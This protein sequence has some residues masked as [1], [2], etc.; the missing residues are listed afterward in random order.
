[1]PPSAASKRPV[2]ALAPVKAPAS[3]P[4]SSDSISVSGSAPTFT[5]TYG[6][7]LTVEFACTTS[8][9]T[10][11]PAPF[12]PVISTG[13]SACATR[14]AV[15][16]ERVHRLALVD[17]AL[18]VEARCELAA[19]ERAAAA[20]RAVLGARARAGRGGSCTVVRS[21]ALSQGFAT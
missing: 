11:L 3:V 12:G 13:T 10:S 5:F 19:R 15:D 21:R 1:M 4:N 8:A 9:I 18:Q 6:P 16:G 14:T 7:S 2:R 17:Q 20:D